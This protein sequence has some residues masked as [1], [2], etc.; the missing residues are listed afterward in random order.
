MTKILALIPAYNEAAHI[1]EVVTSAR[2]QL[3]VLVV[4]ACMRA[5]ERR[6]ICGASDWRIQTPGS[7]NGSSTGTMVLPIGASWNWC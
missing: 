2:A 3:P 4:P 1:V 6:Y 5:P 7:S